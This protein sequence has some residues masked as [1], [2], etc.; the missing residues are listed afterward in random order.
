[1]NQKEANRNVKLYAW[2]KTIGMPFFWGPVIITYIINVGKMSLSEL[3]FMEAVVVFALIFV[4]IYSSA[5]ADLLGR[6]K[7]MILGSFL[8]LVAMILFASLNS[9]FLVWVSNILVMLGFA[10]ASG[11]D[12]AFLVDNLKELGKE[13]ELTRVNGQILSRIF[14]I[15]AIGSI[16]SG[17]LYD[18]NPRLPMFLSVP[19]MFV[20]FVLTF[21]FKESKNTEK[22]SHKEHFDFMK[23]SILFVVNHKAIKWIIAY[24]ALIAV[25]S[26][27]WFFTYNP[28]F[29]LVELD[30]KY[31]GWVF[32]SLNI[33]A[34]ASSKYAY[35]IERKMSELSIIIFMLILMGVPILLMGVFV[36]Q[37]AI[38]LVL[39]ENLVRGFKQPFF[40]SF[41]NRHLDSKNRATVL[42]IKSA[43][44]ALVQAVSL[45]TFGLVLLKWELGMSLQIL[46]VTI[47]V[48]GI[49]S[50]W[51]YK[52]I[53]KN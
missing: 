1:M 16:A 39:S 29:E 5:W 3:Y 36:S 28:Y 49:F 20:S 42:S 6:R 21:F 38:V 18:I 24:V 37:L 25:A 30:Y 35:K 7:A 31:F 2:F 19:G 50:I 27:L 13:D 17:Y 23:M 46:G 32:F 22:I 45:W 41:I 33:V 4:E 10:I 44:I 40:S 34:W 53:F 12:E 15:L 26:K 8:Q 43:S 14:I 9:P 48:L 47:L 51:K 11:A 52:K